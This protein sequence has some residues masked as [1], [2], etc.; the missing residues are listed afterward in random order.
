MGF[1]DLAG[2]FGR[3]PVQ[4]P[5]QFAH[6]LAAPSH[7]QGRA[8]FSTEFGRECGQLA[9]GIDGAVEEAVGNAQGQRHQ[10]Q[11]DRCDVEPGRAG[12]FHVAG[13]VE[14][15]A[16]PSTFL[17]IP[18]VA[19]CSLNR[20]ED[21]CVYPDVLIARRFGLLG[22]SGLLASKKGGLQLTVGLLPHAKHLL[23][24]RLHHQ[25]GFD[26]RHRDHFLHHLLQRRKVLFHQGCGSGPNAQVGQRLC[27]SMALFN[28]ALYA[29]LI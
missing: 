3:G 9:H 23:A 28:C 16:D 26:S 29:A 22:R 14:F 8:R 15:Q 19:A 27:P 13:I 11:R 10:G 1:R 6:F 25:N 21:G 7:A 12:D 17:P 2:Q 20:I 24:S 5:A 18:R 4:R